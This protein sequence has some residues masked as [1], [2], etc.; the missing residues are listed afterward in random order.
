MR[1]AL[2]GLDPEVMGTAPAMIAVTMDVSPEYDRKLAATL[3]HRSQFGL[4]AEIMRDP[5]PEAAPLVQVIGKLITKAESFVLGGMRGPVRN[6]P[7]QDL[8]E[9]LKVTLELQGARR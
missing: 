4:S 1:P 5:P 8:F 6:W 2:G 9:G 3:E 7:L